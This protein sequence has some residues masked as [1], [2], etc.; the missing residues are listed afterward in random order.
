MWKFIILYPGSLRED[1]CYLPRTTQY[2][3]RYM[4]VSSCFCVM[5][6]LSLS[7]IPNFQLGLMT[8]R[9]ISFFGIGARIGVPIAFLHA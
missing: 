4:H 6:S 5:M 2:F 3:Y 9:G 7:I 8:Q 1:G